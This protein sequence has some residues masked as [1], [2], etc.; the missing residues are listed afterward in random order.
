M[1]A[2]H[3][4]VLLVVPSF[5]ALG[6]WQFG[7]WE[8]EAAQADL[9]QA[10]MNAD[11][12]PPETVTGVGDQV[13]ADD[14][15]TA[16]TAT[17][18]YDTEHEL[19]VRNRDGARG[20]GMHVLTPLVTGDGR[21][22]LVNRGWIEPPP[23]ATEQPDVPPAPEGE[24][25][26]TGRLRPHETPQNTGIEER[27]GLPEGQIMLI[28]TDRI[29]DELPY[30]VYGGYAELTEQLPETDP[31]P[32]PVDAGEFNTW[33]NL[34]YAVQWWVFTGVAVGGWGF[35]MRRELYDARSRT[36]DTPESVPPE[37]PVPAE[38]R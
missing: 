29:A 24:V 10:N 22:L 9:Q 4:L 16:V 14:Q 35:L 36:T 3:A 11:P 21:A 15:W 32:E 8:D 19:L 34:S 27:E 12:V 33:T 6:F 17:G 2:F 23:S 13:A 26:V 38:S 18:T 20:V 37:E 5:I 25:T 30:P 31:A 28:D 1:L 7:R